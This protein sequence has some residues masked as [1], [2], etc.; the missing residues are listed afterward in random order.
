VK[1][2][3][4]ATEFQEQAT[5]IEWAARRKHAGRPLSEW[6]VLINN[7]SLMSMLKTPGQRYAFWHR[8]LRMGFRRGASDLLFAWPAGGRHGL[9][10]EMKRVRAYYGGER[11]QASAVRTEQGMFQE[12]MAAAGY[13]VVVAYGWQEAAAAIESYLATGQE[14]LAC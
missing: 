14:V 9:W 5:L 7:E 8:L 1:A 6:V 4:F 2:R 10:I 12:Q 3:V 13:G 11:S